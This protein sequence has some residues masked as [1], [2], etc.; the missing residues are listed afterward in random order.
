MIF[1][2]CEKVIIGQE[3]NSSTLM[4]ILQGFDV[5]AEP[6]S[7]QIVRLPIPWYIFTL[8][9]RLPDETPGVHVQRMELFAPDQT[10]M[11]AAEVAIIGTDAGSKRFHRSALRR[12]FFA[13]KGVNDHVLKLSMRTGDGPFIDVPNGIFPIPITVRVPQPPIG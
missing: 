3:D 10:R 5:P 2:A 4:S 1:A 12:N 11:L 9:E 8:W 7:D 6:P 13:V